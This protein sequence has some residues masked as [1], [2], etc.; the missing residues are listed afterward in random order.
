MTGDGAVGKVRLR[1]S[2]SPSLYSSSCRCPRHL[3][4]VAVLYVSLA[5]NIPL[6]TCL[7]I[8][9]TTNAFPGEYI[10]TV[11]VKQSAICPLYHR[12]AQ[13]RSGDAAYKRTPAAAR[14]ALTKSLLQFRQLLCERDGRWETN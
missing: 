7:L 8:S 6:Q 10:P 3:D 2:L 12:H 1:N 5:T 13:D 9:Y 14:Y 11:Y 4:V